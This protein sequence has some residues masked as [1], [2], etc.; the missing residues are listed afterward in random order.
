MRIRRR[1]KSALK[2]VRRH[3]A[4][5]LVIIPEEPAQNFELLALVLTAEASVALRKPE[6]KRRRLGEALPILLKDRDLAH[7]VDGRAP[8]RRPGDPAAEVGP[9]RLEG[10]T[11]KGQH[12]RDFE[13]VPRLREVVQPISGQ[14]LPPLLVAEEDWQP[15]DSRQ[16]GSDEVCLRQTRRCRSGRHLSAKML[17]EPLPGERQGGKAADADCQTARRPRIS[18]R[19]DPERRTSI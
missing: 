10:L 2:A 18:Q 19:D 14:S 11:A 12:Q 16:C 7:F 8:L 3:I 17:D 13:T 4:R 5:E 1:R 6:Q 15:C 9:N